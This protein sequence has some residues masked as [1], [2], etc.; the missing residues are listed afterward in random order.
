MGIPAATLQQLYFNSIKIDA[1]AVCVHI[2]TYMY[3]LLDCHRALPDI[4]AK[5]RDVGVLVQ[6][7]TAQLLSTTVAGAET[8]FVKSANLAKV[9]EN[10]LTCAQA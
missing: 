10:H 8:L 2:Y 5:E 9:L 4:L 6:C 3:V 1:F 7:I